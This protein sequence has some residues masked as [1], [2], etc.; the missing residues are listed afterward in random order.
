MVASELASWKLI[1]AV[2][3]PVIVTPKKRSVT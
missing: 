1:P 3:T 2:E